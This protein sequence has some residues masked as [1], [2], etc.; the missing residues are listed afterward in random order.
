M[1]TRF[2]LL[3]F[4]ITR[5]YPCY[6]ASGITVVF[7]LNIYGSTRSTII[8]TLLCLAVML[9]QHRPGLGKIQYPDHQLILSILQTGGSSGSSFC[10]HCREYLVEAA[11]PLHPPA[12]HRAGDPE[13]AMVRLSWQLP[14]CLPL[15]AG[16][17]CRGHQDHVAGT[18]HLCMEALELPEYVLSSEAPVPI[19][20]LAPPSTLPHAMLQASQATCSL[21]AASSTAPV[22][23]AQMKLPP[24]PWGCGFSCGKGNPWAVGGHNLHGPGGEMRQARGVCQAS[25]VSAGANVDG[26]AWGA[27]RFGVQMAQG[28]CRGEG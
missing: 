24:A 16:E 22:P 9:Y 19:L 26:K 8:V 21:L 15:G 17:S 1:S 13:Q 14:T 12:W 4:D 28:V 23:S 18:L 7:L 2:V 11:P 3:Y 27:G 25:P 20:A 6:S 5:L 10:W